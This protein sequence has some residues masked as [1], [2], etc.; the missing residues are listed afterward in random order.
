MTTTAAGTVPL[1]VFH[2]SRD[3]GVGYDETAGYV[4][5]AEGERHARA[6]GADVSGDQS[7]TVW[8]AP[9]TTVARIGT[10]DTAALPQIVLTDYAG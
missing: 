6:L 8:F 9:T 1:T 7:A 3:E 10:A 4:A 5:V 2:V